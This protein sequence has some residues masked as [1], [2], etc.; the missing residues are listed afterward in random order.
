MNFHLICDLEAF[1]FSQTLSS[2]FTIEFTGRYCVVTKSEGCESHYAPSLLDRADRGL[3]AFLYIYFPTTIL[4]F[5]VWNKRGK[6]THLFKQAHEI[7][8]Q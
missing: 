6:R 4:S 8:S 3:L 5:D 2:Y 1:S 7:N